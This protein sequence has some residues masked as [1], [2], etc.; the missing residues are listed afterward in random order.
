MTVK[1]VNVP[2]QFPARDTGA[3]ILKRLG[4]SANDTFNN[5]EAGH[6]ITEYPSSLPPPDQHTPFQRR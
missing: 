2:F 4:G 3:G 1:K 6:D 5:I